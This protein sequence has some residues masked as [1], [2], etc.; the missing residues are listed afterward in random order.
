MASRIYKG[1]KFTEC[2]YCKEAFGINAYRTLV[3]E[4]TKPPKAPFRWKTIGMACESCE[5]KK[6]NFDRWAD[7]A[8]EKKRNNRHTLRIHRPL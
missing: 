1:P 2:Y 3:R 5:N 7:E 6:T 4:A 8:I